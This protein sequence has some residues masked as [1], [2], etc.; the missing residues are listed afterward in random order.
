MEMVG[1]D[2][3]FSFF[4]FSIG[5]SF[6]TCHIHIDYPSRDGTAIRDYIHV[7]DLAQ[8]HLVALNHL[9]EHNPGVKAWNLGSGRG[10]TV[11]EMIKAFNAV[12]GREVPYEVVGRRPGDVLDLTANPRLANKELGWKTEMH[13]ER[14]CA[15]F[16]KWVSNNP[17]GYRQD[18]PAELVAQLTAS[19]A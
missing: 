11:F 14:A 10:S 3:L 4:F 16:W 12:I 15:D 5:C 7:M 17:R 18:A 2:V 13:L 8:G 1:F 9:S 19:E 6:L